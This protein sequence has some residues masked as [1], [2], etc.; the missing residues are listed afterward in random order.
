MS[1]WVGYSALLFGALAIV[2]AVFTEYRQTRARGRVALVATL[3]YAVAAGVLVGLGLIILGKAQSWAQ[4]PWWGY[5]LAFAVTVGGGVSMIN[6][7]R[8]LAS[9]HDMR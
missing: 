2:L 1:V 6:A 7:S 8:W 9:R 3:P 4:L 5:A